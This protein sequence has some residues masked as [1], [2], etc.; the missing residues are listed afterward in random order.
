MT[1]T[2]GRPWP[3]VK[4]SIFPQLQHN[5]VIPGEQNGKGNGGADR[6]FAGGRYVC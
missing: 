5:R 3:A 1:G 2:E 6:I 4:V